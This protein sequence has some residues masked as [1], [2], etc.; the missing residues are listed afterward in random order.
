[1]NRRRSERVPLQMRVEVLAEM[2]DGK[3]ARLEAFT[4]MVNAHGGLLELSLKVAKGQ[5]LL[6]SNPGV[7]AQQ[8]GNVVSVKNS[9]DGFFAVAFE[10]D[11]PSPQFWPIE[12]PPTDWSLMHAK[13]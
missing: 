10:F 13:H 11:S 6:L 9:Q 3:M 4:L 5:K 7:G 8:S 2:E 1:M 12:L